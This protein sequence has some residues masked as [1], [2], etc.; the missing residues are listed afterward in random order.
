MSA[1]AGKGALAEALRLQHEAAELGF[2]WRQLDELWDKLDEE[3]AELKEAATQGR[4]RTQEELGD[5]LFMAV[6]LARHL[7]VDAEAALAGTNAKFAR[8][9]AH[10]CA[11]LEQLPPIGDPRRLDAMEARW[12][13]AKRREK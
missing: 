1:D 5:V 9:F 12:L 10:V 7:G 2:D 8:R 4:L 3:V 6:N 13:E 11:A